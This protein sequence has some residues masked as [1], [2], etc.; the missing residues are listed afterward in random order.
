MWINSDCCVTVSDGPFITNYD[1]RFV[2]IGNG[3][4]RIRIPP[5]LHLP[6]LV[7]NP[8]GCEKTL[9]HSLCESCWLSSTV[10]GRLHYYTVCVNLVDWAALCLWDYTITQSVWILLTEQHRVCEIT[11]LHSLCE[12][13]WL[14]STVSVRLH[15]YTVCV[16][17]VD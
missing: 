15:Y 14:S 8:V 9:L 7:P 2:V 6:Q 11:L 16:N 3:S 4:K 17:L 10:S 5:V 12:S 13:C 1:L